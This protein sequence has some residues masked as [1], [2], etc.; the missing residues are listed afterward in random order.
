MS[1]SSIY[2][3]EPSNAGEPAEF[4]Q[5]ALELI[6]GQTHARGC[7]LGHA[8]ELRVPLEQRL[9]EP[10]RVETDDMSLA[11]AGA[12]RQTDERWRLSFGFP[13][14]AVGRS[15]LLDDVDL[16]FSRVG[17]LVVEGRLTFERL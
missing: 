12:C 8:A 13:Q 14:V 5:Q 3:S 6:A 10:V 4:A 2:S 17:T 9:H 7:L 15:P 1:S 11:A 16:R